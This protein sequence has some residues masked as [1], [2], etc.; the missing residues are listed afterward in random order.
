VEREVTYVHIDSNALSRN[1]IRL[2]KERKWTQV[3][4]ADFAGLSGPAISQLESGASLGHVRTLQKIA[5]AFGIK[6]SEL[7]EGV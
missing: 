2:R 6:V 1:L 3:M 5:V 4:L 7:L